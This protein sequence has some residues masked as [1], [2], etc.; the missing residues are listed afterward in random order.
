MRWINF[1]TKFLL[2][3]EMTLSGFLCD[4]VCSTTQYWNS[5]VLRIRVNF[6]ENSPN[7]REFQYRIGFSRCG[8]ILITQFPSLAAR[9]VY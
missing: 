5:V 6:R 1:P 8:K 3:N 2:E 7:S 4:S 9:V